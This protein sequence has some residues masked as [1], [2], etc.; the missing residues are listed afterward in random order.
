M[1]N[2]NQ[3]LNS[4]Q[5]YEAYKEHTGKRIFVRTPSTFVG[6]QKYC[7]TWCGDTTS[8]TSLVGL[9]Q[10]S[11]QG[12]SNVTADLISNNE[13]QIHSG[14]FM[15]WVL[16]FCW[17]HQVWLWM[18]PEDLQKTYLAYAK[19]RYALMPYVY[20]AAYNTHKSGIPMCT[21]MV[22][23][24]ITAMTISTIITQ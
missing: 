7:G 10:Y 14:M 18:L 17:G 11:F 12:Q 15:P 22:A 19:L 23:P 13:E 21:A 24:I 1:H 9:I 2:L 5:Y 20:T 6:H 3:T 16:N 8:N 4:R